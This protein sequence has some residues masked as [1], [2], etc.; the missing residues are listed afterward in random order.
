MPQ[1]QSLD[2]E[3][4]GFDDA[5]AA[6][7]IDNAFL[8]SLDVGLTKLSGKGL[9]HLCTMKNL[10][11]LDLWAT[12]IKEDDLDLLAGMP[13]EY[14]SIGCVDDDE[15]PLPFSVTSVLKKIEALPALKRIWLDGLDLNAEHLAEFKH[16]NIT[17]RQ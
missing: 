11:S 3:G 16:R 15:S 17:V 4:T 12:C 8:H 9:A 2:L 1:L 10:R 6:L 13:L 7:V 5:I 14:L